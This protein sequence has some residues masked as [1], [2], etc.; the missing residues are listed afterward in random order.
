MVATKSIFL[1]K[2]AYIDYLEG[3]M[4]DG[5]KDYCIHARMKGINEISLYN[6]SN[7]QEGDIPGNNFRMTF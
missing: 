1:G 7:E 3:T 6:K 4:P 2:K 5:K